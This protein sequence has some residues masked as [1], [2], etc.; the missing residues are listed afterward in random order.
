M[1][2]KR[3]P[4]GSA[5]THNAYPFWPAPP[6]KKFESNHSRKQTFTLVGRHLCVSVCFC[7]EVKLL[8]GPYVITDKILGISF[9]V[10]GG[11][12]DRLLSDLVYQHQR[13]R[14]APYPT[15]PPRC[16]LLDDNHS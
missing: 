2:V 12:A 14:F 11:N 6:Q 9:H 7:T 16:V 3:T 1:G 13:P 10:E 8:C 5:S 15:L 4:V